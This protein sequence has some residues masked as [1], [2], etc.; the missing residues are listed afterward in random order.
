MA[1]EPTG[2]WPEPTEDQ[3][4]DGYI[5]TWMSDDESG[6]EATDGCY[7]EM[8]GVCPHGYPSWLLQLGWI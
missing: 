1:V 6:C 2:G 5:E 3:P 4:D 7:V 8:D